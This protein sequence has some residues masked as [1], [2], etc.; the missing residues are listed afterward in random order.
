MC[1]VGNSRQ[2]PGPVVDGSLTAL[3]T[4]WVSLRTDDAGHLREWSA[5]T[6]AT[7]THSTS[8]GAAAVAAAATNCQGIL[9]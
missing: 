8:M 1:P 9:W 5:S 2:N 7:T 3:A 6:T 4:A